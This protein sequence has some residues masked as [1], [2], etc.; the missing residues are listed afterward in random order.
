[1]FVK[2]VM[3]DNFRNII[4]EN[5]EFD[6]KINI[7]SGKNAQG[8]TNIIEALW[9]FSACKSFRTNNDMDFINLNNEQNYCKTEINYIKDDINNNAKMLFMQAK[10]KKIK[11]N[12]TEVKPVEMIGNFNSVLFFPEHLNLIK[13]LPENRRKF[14]DFAISQVKPKYFNIINEYNKTLMQKNRA[15]KNYENKFLDTLDIWDAK[16][17]KLCVYIARIRNNYIRQIEKYAQKQLLQMSGEKEIL[18]LKY[19]SMCEINGKDTEWL[20][21]DYLELFRQNRNQELRMMHSI[22]GIH[23]DDIEIYINNTAAKT[24]GSQGQQR[25]CVMALKLAEA[26]ILND[27]YG[28][29]PVLLLDDVFSELDSERKYFIIDKIIEKQVIITTCEKIED[30]RHAKIFNINSG[31][32]EE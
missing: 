18:S 16:L 10:R 22:S 13:G 19:K 23:R 5:I 30:F 1:M 2:N 6:N 21:N 3:L 31:K 7:L 28:E 9:L 11:L 24:F 8:K 29:Y 27:A 4:S 32:I 14:L 15:L 26:D 17:V 20:E 25:S 12:N